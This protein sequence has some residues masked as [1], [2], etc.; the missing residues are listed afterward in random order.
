MMNVPQVTRITARPN[1]NS[2]GAVLPQRREPVLPALQHQPLRVLQSGR[3]P[4]QLSLFL[5][6]GTR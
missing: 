4:A 2:G 3:P 5:R 6:P 1:A